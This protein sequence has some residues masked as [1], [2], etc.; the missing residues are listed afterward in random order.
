MSQAPDGS[1]L[2][3]RP[4]TWMQ[5]G[6]PVEADAA[7][8]A[9]AKKTRRGFNSW[10]HSFYLGKRGK[11]GL[12]RGLVTEGPDDSREPP[13]AA[14]SRAS[15]AEDVQLDSVRP[16]NEKPKDE[17]QWAI[18]YENQRGITLFS[19]TYYSRLSLLPT[20]PPAFTLPYAGPSSSS[21]GREARRHQPRITKLSEYP[22]PDGTWEWVSQSWM[23]DMREDGEVQHDGF[24][25]NWLFRRHDW[26]AQVGKFN[27]G[28]WVRRRRWVRLMVRRAEAIPGPMSSNIEMGDI[29][30][31][32]PG[33]VRPSPAPSVL[34]PSSDI[35]GPDKSIIIETWQGDEYH[36]WQRCHAV[37]RRLPRD[38]RKLELWALWL[39]L[40]HRT[41]VSPVTSPLPA[42]DA[43]EETLK[44]RNKKQWTEDEGPLPSEIAYTNRISNTVPCAPLEY[45]GPVVRAHLGPLLE[46]FVFPD[47]RVR[48]MRQ[49][50]QVGLLPDPESESGREF[51][52]YRTEFQELMHPP[53]DLAMGNV[54]SL[55][56]DEEFKPV[57]EPR[58]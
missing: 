44:P 12:Q 28:G 7:R 37:M 48:F 46:L 51:W 27:A 36:D 49:L 6:D 55:P 52:S 47:S 21:S 30:D 39:G 11:Q 53:K 26:R 5:T 10:L 20:D 29:D 13:G 50:A 41:T 2:A 15:T 22:L 19:S 38:G 4:P 34:D 32:G 54:P 43:A 23:V 8:Q 18:L 25:Y 56:Q 9:I 31:A 35:E 16:R 14:S 17:Y 58:E 42:G 45:I 33:S 3:R 40:P 57:R 1:R 24:E